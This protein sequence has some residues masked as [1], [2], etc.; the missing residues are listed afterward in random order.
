MSTPV[1]N[2]Y[3]DSG[4]ID[5]IIDS[6]CYVIHSQRVDFK[7]NSFTFDTKYLAGGERIIA[8]ASTTPRGMGS[9]T[10]SNVT[11]VRVTGNTVS[12]TYVSGRG[13]GSSTIPVITIFKLVGKK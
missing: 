7:N 10:Y 8:V 4:V 6:F 12:W 3:H 2:V 13:A 5:N 1:F 11:N 9:V